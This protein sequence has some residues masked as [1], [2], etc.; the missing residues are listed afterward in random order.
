MPTVLRIAAYRLFFYAGDRDERQHV[1]VERDNHLAKI[2]LNPIS[3]QTR[4]GFSETDIR[5]IKLVE[6]NREILT[7]RWNEFFND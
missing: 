4:G 5:R 7:R 2:W 6:Q 1:H 3:L